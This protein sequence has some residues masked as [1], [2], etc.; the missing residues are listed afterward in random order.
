MKIGILHER[1]RKDEKLLV[2]AAEKRDI[3]VEL[4]NDE[5]VVFKLERNGF[6][7]DLVIERCIN[8]ARALASL[9]I[10]NELG[11]PTIN[12][13]ECAEICGSKFLVTEALLK[14]GVPTPKVC[15]AFSKEATLEAVKQ[16]GL[17]C[18]FK[19]AIGSWGTLLAKAN[20]MD[21]AEAIVDHKEKL[22]SYHHSVFYIQEYIEKPGRDIR[23]F[24]VGDE[25]VGAVYRTGEHWI[26]HVD[27]NAVLSRC[28]VTAELKKIALR[29]TRAVM[30]EIVAVDIVEAADGL[31]VIEVEYTV[32]FS[33]FF[34]ELDSSVVAKML[35]YCVARIK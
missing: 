15:I 20:D 32:E 29:A 19:P 28:P 2:E 3:E 23:V 1:M 6:D 16:M 34:P 21:A 11:I 22:G 10:F 7:F 35:D 14:N 9:R 8:H 31:K 33:K 26:T 4:I 17:P 12:S 18:V 25:V 30:G 24:V 5:E 13:A 27:R